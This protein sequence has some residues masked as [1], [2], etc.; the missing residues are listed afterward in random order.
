MKLTI[1]SKTCALVAVFLVAG[2]NYVDLTRV[3][4]PNN[5]SVEQFLSSP[6]RG[7]LN[8]MAIGL[9]SAIRFV[10]TGTT[11]HYLSFGAAGREVLQ[12]LTTDQRTL[13]QL[14]GQGAFDPDAFVG[15]YYGAAY[16]LRR[17]ASEFA[18]AASNATGISDAERQAC[19]GFANTIQ[20]YAF[21]IVANGRWQ[22]GIRMD[23]LDNFA[24]TPG[25]LIPY[26][27]AMQRIQ[28]LYDLGAQQL[29]AGGAAFPFTM[30][31][32][33]AGFDTPANFRQVNRALVARVLLYQQN[34]SAA[35]TLLAPGGGTFI[36]VGGSLANG[37]VLT[38]STAAG[39]NANPFFV[40]TNS[41]NPISPAN[42]WVVS[43]DPGDTRVTTKTR[44]RS[45]PIN[46]FGISATN[47]SQL[48]ASTSASLSFIR[49]EELI[50]MRA[51][52]LAQTN[53]LTNA[54]AMINLVRTAA[55][56]GN[57]TG[58][59]TQSAL[60]D[61]VLKQRRYSL[62]FEGHR[63]VDM[64]R[65]NRLNQLPLINAGGVIYDRFPIPNQ[66]IAIGGL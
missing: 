26:N 63:W 56:V 65:Y 32:G 3:N 20:A 10:H 12:F 19:L 4:D 64:R 38:F 61:E 14:L 7:Q 58:A 11:N 31:S 16:N 33:W 2:C 29:A 28:A 45:T 9:Q 27:T 15:A 24:G 35:A 6:N 13:T 1:I 54:V 47:E 62:W 60:I 59:V 8:L 49:N 46:L 66:E 57:Y 55:G 50:L 22:D 41:P 40:A 48:Y 39:D 30:T 37:P 17:R 43:A 44:V 53:D 5:P 52:A 18:T 42:D 23:N 34:W 51:E 36:N 25:P 21:T